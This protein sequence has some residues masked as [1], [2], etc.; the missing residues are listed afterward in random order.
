MGIAS[1]GL[2]PGPGIRLWINPAVFPQVFFWIGRKTG[3][4]TEKGQAFSEG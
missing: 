4:I 3:K 1:P 2:A